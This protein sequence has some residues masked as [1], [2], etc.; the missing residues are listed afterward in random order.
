MMNISEY[1]VKLVSTDS[2]CIVITVTSQS[3]IQVLTINVIMVDKTSTSSCELSVKIIKIQGSLLKHPAVSPFV[4]NVMRERERE[5][6][7]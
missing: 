5:R 7:S 2:Q 4:L 3:S 1:T 6:D